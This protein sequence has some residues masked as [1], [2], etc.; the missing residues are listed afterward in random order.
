MNSCLDFSDT[1]NCFIYLLV[2]QKET[3]EDWTQETF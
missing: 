2:R 3:A 1:I